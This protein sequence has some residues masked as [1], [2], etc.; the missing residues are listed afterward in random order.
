MKFDPLDGAVLQTSYMINGNRQ[1]IV[2]VDVC[3]YNTVISCQENNKVYHITVPSEKHEFVMVSLCQFMVPQ[4]KTLF[5]LF[6]F[7]HITVL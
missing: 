3:A 1:T 4:T 6:S 7:Y 2:F 5:V